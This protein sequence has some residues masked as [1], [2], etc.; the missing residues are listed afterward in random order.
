MRGQHRDELGRISQPMA[1]LGDLRNAA[2][3][4]VE[5]RAAQA[6]YNAR[7]HFVSLNISLLRRPTRVSKAVLSEMESLGVS[8]EL[9]EQSRA[10]GNAVENVCEYR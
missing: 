10:L 1:K 2:E 9:N 7:G 6:G 5:Q 8:M 4:G 3:S